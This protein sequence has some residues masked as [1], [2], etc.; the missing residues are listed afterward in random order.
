MTAYIQIYKQNE[1]YPWTFDI[2]TLSDIDKGDVPSLTFS[3]ETNN[4]PDFMQL[5]QNQNTFSFKIPD[6]SAEIVKAG[7]YSIR[8]TV[9]D[10]RESYTS[11]ITIVVHEAPVFETPESSTSNASSTQSTDSPISIT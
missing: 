1:P 5:L 8:M 10:L 9:S 2:P 4:S 7:T 11:D 3:F 6:L